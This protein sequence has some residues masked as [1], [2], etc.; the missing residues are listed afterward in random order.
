[1]NKIRKWLSLLVTITAL[2]GA[3]I[4][5]QAIEPDVNVPASP[6]KY[7]YLST[8][9]LSFDGQTLETEAGSFLVDSA[10]KVTDHRVLDEN[11][12]LPKQARVEL[13]LEDGALREVVIF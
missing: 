6:D 3:A 1:M 8:E 13:S 11:G 12:N 7:S 2:G 5:A 4:S 10:V 9:L